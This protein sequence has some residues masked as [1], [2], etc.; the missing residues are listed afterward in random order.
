MER[1]RIV[2][3]KDR[4]KLAKLLAGEGQVLAPLLGLIETAELGLNELIDVIGRAGIEALLELS[5]GEVAG[6]KQKGKR[7]DDRAVRWY[8]H[9][10]GMVQ[11]P[12]RKVRVE[13][14]R[15]RRKGKGKDAEVPIPVYETMQSDGSVAERILSIVLAGVSTRRYAEVLPAMAESV[16]MSKSSVSR[17]TV[18]A[19]EA[20]LRAVCERRFDEVPL[21]VIY[22]DGV[23][24]GGHHV[25]VAVGVDEKG[26]KHLLGLREGATENAAVVTALL[27]DLVEREVR[28]DRHYLFVI[29]GSKALRTAIRKVYG[30][31]MPVQ[32]C[33]PHKERNVRD[34]LHKERQAQVTSAMKAAWKLPADEGVRKLQ[35]L[36]RW[37]EREHPSAAESLREGLEEMFTV[38]RM[39]LSPALRRCLGSTN[40]IESSLSGTSQKAANVR[41]WRDGAMVT[42]WVA[43]GLVETEKHFRKVMGYRDLWQLQA[44]LREL[45]V[46]QGLVRERKVG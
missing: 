38:N 2:D 45:D 11:L 40:V 43:A 46:K 20:T 42:R 8:G 1:Y 27:E 31:T 35:D 34:H 6:P 37:L 24:R 23:Q 28:A 18:E 44:H 9:Q 7:R 5:A 13:K 16:G 41:R 30:E 25:I 26:Y 19:C 17:E 22:V 21:L 15:L 39:N 12:E 4:R 3:K 32:R 10:D 14:P 33:R 29:D 36:A